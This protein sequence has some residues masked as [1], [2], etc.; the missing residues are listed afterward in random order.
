MRQTLFALRSNAAFFMN[1][2][3]VATLRQRLKAALLIYDKVILQD[4]RYYCTVFD[5]GVFD[6]FLP[7]QAMTREQRLQYSFQQPGKEARLSVGE[8]PGSQ[9]HVLISGVPTAYYNADFFPLVEEAGLRGH[10]AVEI[11]QGDWN[12]PITDPAMR[13]WKTHRGPLRQLHHDQNQFYADKASQAFLFD[14]TAAAH[15]GLSFNLDHRS[16]RIA[17]W[18]R[19]HQLAQI[20]DEIAAVFLNG[21]IDLGLPDFTNEPWDKLIALRDSAAGASFRQLIAEIEQQVA[22]EASNVTS[23]EDLT[24]LVNR[25]FVTKMAEELFSRKVSAGQ[26]FFSLGLNFTPLSL[27]GNV[28]EFRDALKDGRSW[29]N[30]LQPPGPRA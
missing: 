5:R 26:A 1:P 28:K 7:L 20:K 23:S 6:G 17:E 10:P 15:F 16:H 13:F 3:T 2:A 30:L 27:I 24:S 19:A 18:V 14:A 22:A 4:G 8:T 29:I 25:K 11:L 9:G 12:T 21:W